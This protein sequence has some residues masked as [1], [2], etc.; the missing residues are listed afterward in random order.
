MVWQG[1]EPTLMGLPFARSNSS[2]PAQI[3]SVIEHTIQTN[4]TLIDDGWAAFRRR[5]FLDRVGRPG[6]I[7]DANRVDKGGKPT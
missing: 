6:E 4:A 7:H 2:T 3:W 5:T 1:G